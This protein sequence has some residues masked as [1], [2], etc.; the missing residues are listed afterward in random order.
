[1]YNKEAKRNG[2]DNHI[3]NMAINNLSFA[4]QSLTI[5][6]DHRLLKRYD[7]WIGDTGATSHLTLSL[8]NATNQQE[9]TATIQ[10]VSGK[11]I[12]PDMLIDI[13]CIAFDNKGN[14]VSTMRM[15]NVNFI[16]N[17]NY[18]LF[19]L[20]KILR[21]GWTM[22]GNP[23]RIVMKKDTQPVTFDIKIETPNGVLYCARL[24]RTEIALAGSNVDGK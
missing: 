1:M 13:D 10:G 12:R 4:L 24:K 15:N 19:S 9:L 23:E 21:S 7:I 8:L 20:T 22:H 18:N 3:N 2:D 11:G 16:G 5:G 14:E 17:S 6:N